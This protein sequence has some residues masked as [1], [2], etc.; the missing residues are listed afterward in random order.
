MGLNRTVDAKTHPVTWMVIGAMAAGLGQL[1]TSGER[2]TWRLMLGRALSSGALGVAAGAVLVWH[3]DTH[4]LAL[5]GLAAG[6]GS[7]GTSGLERV[8]QKVFGGK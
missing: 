2:L 4:P 8:A 3:P 5:A 6:L 7:L 1:L